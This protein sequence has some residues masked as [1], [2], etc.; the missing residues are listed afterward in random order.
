MLKFNIFLTRLL[1]IDIPL[2]QATESERS[3]PHEQ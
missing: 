1:D 2:I 3:S